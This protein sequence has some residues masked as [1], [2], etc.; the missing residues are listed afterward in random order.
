MCLWCL[1]G[2]LNFIAL[3]INI[4]MVKEHKSLIFFSK[5][6]SGMLLTSQLHIVPRHCR[7]R[8]K[9]LGQQ[10]KFLGFAVAESSQGKKKLIRCIYSLNSCPWK[11]ESPHSVLSH[12]WP[13]IFYL[14]TVC[15]VIIGCR[16]SATL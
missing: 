10:F 15:I 14:S 4:Y 2:N 16:D 3:N 11:F 1:S 9:T 8:R 12:L 6:L 5:Q 7:G 13:L